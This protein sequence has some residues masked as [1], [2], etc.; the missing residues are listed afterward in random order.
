MFFQFIGNKFEV[1]NITKATKNKLSGNIF[2]LF[3]ERMLKHNPNEGN[4]YK[5]CL[6]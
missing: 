2:Q 5:A 6:V 4:I 1:G 3:K